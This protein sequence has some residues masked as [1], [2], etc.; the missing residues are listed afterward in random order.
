MRCEKRS[1]LYTSNGNS[2]D[3]WSGLTMDQ[4]KGKCTKNEVPDTSCSPEKCAYVEYDKTI[5][6]ESMC[7]LADGTCKPIR[8]KTSFSKI[9]KKAGANKHKL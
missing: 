2:C 6:T 4:C 3:G 9:V 1:S 5:A 7:H 8:A